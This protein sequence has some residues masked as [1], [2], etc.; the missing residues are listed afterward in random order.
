MQQENNNLQTESYMNNTIVSDQLSALMYNL[1]AAAGK[2]GI[3]AREAG[4]SLQK[5]VQI[6]DKEK[7]KYCYTKDILEELADRWNEIG[8][9][10]AVSLEEIS[11]GLLRPETSGATETPNQNEPFDFLE[12]NAYDEADSGWLTP[13]DSI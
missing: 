11:Q 2:V 7:Q 10:N 1:S 9:I 12:Q 6:F 5:I 3:S 4:N 8:C 13:L